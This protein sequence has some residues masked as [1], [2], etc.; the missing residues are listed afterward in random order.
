MRVSASLNE[1]IGG[2]I[3]GATVKSIQASDE[4]GRAAGARD[5]RAVADRVDIE[6]L[7]GEFV[8]ALMTGDYDRFASLFAEEGV[9][10]IPYI[11]VELVGRGEIRAGIE[12]MQALWAYFVQ[13]SHPGTI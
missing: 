9:W 4:R 2:K 3:E 6:A 7:R 12:R 8:D 1:E 11:D 10:R 13:T 5:L